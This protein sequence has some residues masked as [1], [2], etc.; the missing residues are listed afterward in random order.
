MWGTSGL[1][2]QEGGVCLLFS[3]S[4]TSR[5]MGAG[6]D[7]SGHEDEGHIQEIIGQKERKGLGPC[8]LPKGKPPNFL[9]RENNLLAD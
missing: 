3:P 2:L 1:C 9:M 4:F 7:H 8:L 5:N 6:M